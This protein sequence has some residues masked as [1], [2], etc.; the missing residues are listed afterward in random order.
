MSAQNRDEGNNGGDGRL[1]G[2]M[3][4]GRPGLPLLATMGFP[5]YRLLD[6][7]HGRKLERFGQVVVDRPEP[8]A[9]WRPRLPA[10]T[11]AAA[12]GVFAGENDKESDGGSEAGRWRLRPGAPDRWPLAVEG[13]TLA[14]RFSAFRH[15]G[16]FPEHLP[17]WQWM[18]GELARLSARPS[19]GDGARPRVLNLFGYTGA[20][21]LLAAAAGAE[22][23][24]V[25]ASRKAVEWARENQQ[26][27]GLTQAPI[28]WIVEDARKFVQ[29]E[30]RR[31]RRYH[32]IILDP[33]KF[34]RG[35][36]GEVWELFDH[37]PALLR[38]CAALLEP[39][40]ARLILT[41]YAIRASALSFH[42]LLQD[43]LEDRPGMVDSGELVLAEEN[44]QRALSTSLYSRWSSDG[45][46]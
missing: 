41:V 15:L 16:V 30:G 6:S 36:E 38:D 31:G 37:L 5:D 43:I 14:C 17:H 44:G 22:V 39:A 24:H 21:S 9:L 42:L 1:W 26:A 32:L 2:Q 40:G 20:A 25:D 29:R 12:D 45:A 27:S 7:G 18:R 4:P 13:L 3:E 33:P 34:G 28:R 11:W 35:A 19:D 10:A 23:V 8:Q 46:P